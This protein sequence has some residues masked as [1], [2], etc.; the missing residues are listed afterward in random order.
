MEMT[1]MKGIIFSESMLDWDSLYCIIPFEVIGRWTPTKEDARKAEKVV[2]EYIANENR[3]IYARWEQYYRQYV[4]I[5]DNSGKHLIW[6]NYFTESDVNCEDN[7][8]CYWQETVITVC[9]GGHYFFNVVVD[10]HA[11]KCIEY[12]VNGE[13]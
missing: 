7:F 5:I 3:K 8:L 4:G 11:E 13:A 2:K 6:I 10:L 1:A 12:H 9:D